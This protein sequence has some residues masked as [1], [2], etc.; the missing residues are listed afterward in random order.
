MNGA[1]RGGARSG[2][3]LARALA[4]L[5]LAAIGLVACG[6]DDGSTTASEPAD[7][8]LRV[9]V[10]PPRAGPSDVVRAR[11]VNDSSE[12][13]TYGLAYVL[14]MQEGDS[15]VKVSEPRVVPEIGLVAKPGETG[16]PVKVRIPEDAV[17]GQ[18]RIVIQRDVPDVGDLSGELEVTGDY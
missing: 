7:A 3:L 2:G 8:G 13:F 11:V 12:T 18:Y 17:A 6:D 1:R 14:E 5:L 4:L 16:P 15:F 9:E 10:T